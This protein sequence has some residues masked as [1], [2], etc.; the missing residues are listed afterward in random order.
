MGIKD[1]TRKELEER[2]RELENIIAHKGVGSSYL[3]KAE[4]IQRDINIAL[5]LGA[6]TAVVGLTAWAVYK[7]RGE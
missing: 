3:Q 7:S 2:V 5:L 4:R 1:K 6:T